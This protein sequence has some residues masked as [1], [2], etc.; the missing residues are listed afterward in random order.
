MNKIFGIDISEWQK[1]FDFK[2]AKSEGVKFAIIRAGYTGSGNGTSKAKDKCFESHY[3]NAKNNGIQVGAYWFSRATTYANGQ[4]EA[5]YMYKNCLKGK[6]F[7]YP[8]AI[9]VEDTKYQSKASKKAVAEAVKGFCEYLEGKGYYVSVYANSNWFKNKI[10]STIIK[11]YDK[12]LANWSK[13]N[14]TSPKHGMWQFGGSSN[15]VR[16]NKVAGVVCDQDYAYKDYPN[17]M[18]EKGLNGYTKKA[19]STP[20]DPPKPQET[21]QNETKPTETTKPSSEPK[22]SLE[23]GDKVQII[24]N[25]NSQASGKGYT[26]GG[27]GYKRKIK[28]YIAG[29]KYPYKVGNA[30]GTTGWYQEKALKKI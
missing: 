29:A 19:E 27:I 15:Y 13:S 28:D 9:D 11:P 24:G 17:I 10:D 2:K 1:G 6:Q 4:A 14:P 12:W 25:G 26:A 20:V 5:E 30:F 18:L 16:T 3:K 22:K 21:P 7:E 8:I 23:K